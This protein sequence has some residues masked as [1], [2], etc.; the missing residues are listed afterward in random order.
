MS[1]KTKPDDGRGLIGVCLFLL[2]FFSAVFFLVQAGQIFYTGKIDTHLI[3]FEGI[4]G[5]LAVIC[6]PIGIWIRSTLPE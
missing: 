6:L 1:L 5:S 2:G 4:T 3:T